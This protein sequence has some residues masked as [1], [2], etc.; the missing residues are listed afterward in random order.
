MEPA[1]Q[2][3]SGYLV[4]RKGLDQTKCCMCM[5][6]TLATQ[7]FAWR[8]SIAANLKS[9]VK[10]PD[11]C[12]TA[13]RPYTFDK[14]NNPAKPSPRHDLLRCLLAW[15]CPVVFTLAHA[16]YLQLAGTSCALCC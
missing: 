6:N 11:P 10:H 1:W 8:Q 16:V 9:E 2:I 13:V 4:N 5:R 7:M 14:S 12:A 3:C 15:P